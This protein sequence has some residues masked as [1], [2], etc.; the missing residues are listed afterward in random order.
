M[1][2]LDIF[3]ENSISSQIGNEKLAQAILFSTSICSN[4]SGG[5]FMLIDEIERISLTPFISFSFY[6]LVSVVDKMASTVIIHSNF[7]HPLS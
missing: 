5:D 4:P 6:H 3:D 1:N 2:C 7:R